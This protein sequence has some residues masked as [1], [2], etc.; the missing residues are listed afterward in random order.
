[1]RHTPRRLSAV[2]TASALA[3]LVPS[4]VS[5]DAPEPSGTV[6][7]TALGTYD[8]GGLARAE[9]VAFDAPSA[10]MFISNDDENQVDIVDISDP[11]A[12]TMVSSVYM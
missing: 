1:M 12:P 7:L 9:V 8:G 3:L 10:R 5:A 4:V 11:T 2:L 6:T